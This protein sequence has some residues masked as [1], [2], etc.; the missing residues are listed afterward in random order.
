MP[1]DKIKT[2]DVGQQMYT[3]THNLCMPKIIKSLLES[4][5]K[6][7]ERLSCSGTLSQPI[8]NIHDMLIKIGGRLL[9]KDDKTYQYSYVWDSSYIKIV[10][11][12]KT[13]VLSLDGISTDEKVSALVKEIE[14]LL[15]QDKKNF[16]FTIIKGSFGLEARN[17]GDASSPLIIDNYNKEVIDGIEY[18]N[19][20]F[21]A[22]PPKGR[23]AIFN[24]EPG[25]GKTHLIRTMLSQID[26][27]F[28]IIPSNLIDSLDK[29]E[30]MPFI[31]GL[32]DSYKKPIIMIIED[33]DACLVPRKA[34][35]MS[36][37]AALLNITDGI[38]GTML[39]IKVIISTNSYI[40]QIDPAILRP[41]RLCK[42]IHVGPLEY[43]QANKVYQKLMQNEKESLPYKKTYVLAEIYAIV[44]N[45]DNEVIN[46]MPIRRTIGFDV[47]S[48]SNSSF[49]NKT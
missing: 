42:Q 33:G 30:F 38:I 15:S 6:V 11:Y 2:V 29:P 10:Y 3:D 18:V 17:M 19:K 39:D 46:T 49:V 7:L 21:I 28:L 12:A 43:A 35:N 1:K 47:S 40:E 45:I 41:G 32:K 22:S 25:T 23:I 20:S 4:D 5:S 14:P 24:G 34:D 44:S 36:T 27:L 37:I 31:L 9:I 8:Q 26:S 16:I 13:N 48:N